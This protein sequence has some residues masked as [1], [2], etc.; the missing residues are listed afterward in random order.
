MA[1][2][3]GSFFKVIIAVGLHGHYAGTNGRFRSTIIH[4]GT[5]WTAAAIKATHCAP[6]P[7]NQGD[8]IPEGLR[9]NA[10]EAAYRVSNGGVDVF[11][12]SKVVAVRVRKRFPQVQETRANHLF[13]VVLA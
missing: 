13:R 5:R 8:T 2:F 9:N 4:L 6:Q 10:C 1:H 3:A 12:I 11:N 7:F